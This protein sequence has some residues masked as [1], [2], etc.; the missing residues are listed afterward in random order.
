MS[1]NKILEA[2]Q[3]TARIDEDDFD[4][5][6]EDEF[7]E[8]E[9]SED[10]FSNSPTEDIEEFHTLEEVQEF[11]MDAVEQKLED[12]ETSFDITLE[13]GD[14]KPSIEY[15]MI[16]VDKESPIFGQQNCQEGDKVLAKTYTKHTGEASTD[17][18]LFRDQVYVL[19]P[20]EDEEGYDT[21]EITTLSEYAQREVEVLSSELEYLFLID[22]SEP[23]LPEPDTT[24]VEDTSIEES[25]DI[26]TQDDFSEDDLDSTDEDSEIEENILYINLIPFLEE[27]DA[28]VYTTEEGDVL[29]KIADKTMVIGGDDE[30]GYTFVEFIGDSEEINNSF[31]TH[32]FNELSSYITE[33]IENA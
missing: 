18:V 16:T 27:T 19:T 6:S 32:D 1:M 28:E 17:Y 31:L 33:S 25:E 8:D 7:S 29:I 20:K 4:E 26:D 23:S 15:Q 30:R 9:F 22:D 21:L 11:L 10:E 5:F 3:K 12:I 14:I 13:E 24:P 2:W